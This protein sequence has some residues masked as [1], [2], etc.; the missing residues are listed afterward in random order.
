M[1]TD[2]CCACELPRRLLRGNLVVT[3]QDEPPLTPGFVLIGEDGTVLSVGSEVPP[4]GTFDEVLE[5]DVIGPGLIDMHNHGI[6]GATVETA[7]GDY[8]LTPEYTLSKLPRHGTT[9]LVATVVFDA[10]NMNQTYACC[11]RLNALLG[12][13]GHGAVLGGIHAE[14]PC[15]AT[16]GGLP[17]ARA[18]NGYDAAKFEAMLDSIGSGL[19]V[20]TISAS[21]DSASLSGGDGA[22]FERIRRLLSRNVT[23]ALGHDK[24]CTIAQICGALRAAASADSRLH[25]THTFNVQT[26]HH[27]EC[28]LANVALLPRLPAGSEFDGAQPPTLELI[29]DHCHVSPLALQL[30]LSSRDPLDICFVTDAIAEP[31]AGRAVHYA[32]TTT[33][34]ASDGLTVGRRGVAAHD[35]PW[36]LCGSCTNLHATLLKLVREHH[37]PVTDAIKMLS[38]NPARIA[39]LSRGGSLKVGQ[40]ADAVLLD[41]PPRLSVRWTLVGGRVVFE[42]R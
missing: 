40:P 3:A 16:L 29:G 32:G 41:A 33:H 15:I 4:D 13:E 31:V 28:G 21:I 14:G 10:T 42:G 25:V 1:D 2:A 20:M 30:A 39:R 8:W 12:H 6:G 36:V 37:V 7:V 35:A 23:P 9:G 5:A 22:P 17:E 38:C 24:E 26:L 27:R 18:A 11:D 19:R 34:V